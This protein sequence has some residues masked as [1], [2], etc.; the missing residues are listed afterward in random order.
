MDFSDA[1]IA[2][3]RMVECTKWM[4]AHHVQVGKAR[5]VRAMFSDRKKQLLARFSTP[6]LN[7]QGKPVSLA[8][9]ESEARKNPEYEI[10]LKSL[11][12]QVEAAEILLAQADANDSSFEAARSMNSFNRESLRQLEG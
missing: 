2:Q 12:E 3:A 9:A 8:V 6:G 10:G 7:A 1:Q 4:H 11:I 5:V